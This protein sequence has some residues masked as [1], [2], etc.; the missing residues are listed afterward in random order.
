VSAALSGPFLAASG[1]LC[2]SGAA[3][4]RSP[5]AALP[6]LALLGLPS[7]TSVVRAVA[8]AEL[9]IGLAGLIAP[10]RATA[11]VIAAAYATFAV[12][13]TRLAA[14][15]ASCGCF[16]ESEAAASPVQALL[17]GALAIVAIAAAASPPG[18]LQWVLAQPVA[19]AATLILGVGAG[20]YGVVIAYT[21]LPSA[22][23]AW[24]AQ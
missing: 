6:T 1:V 18:G 16:G 19:T 5:R 7:R 20:V 23:G 3:K 4:L 13:A 17:S 8:T 12:L 21:Q 24:S 11:L 10:S 9:A 22:W 2:V 15:R 14:L